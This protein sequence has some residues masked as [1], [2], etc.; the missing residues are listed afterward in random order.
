MSNDFFGYVKRMKYIKRWS[1]MHST[2][3]ENDMEHSM[4]VTVIAHAIALI[5]NK[6]FNKAYDINKVLTY[7]IYHECSEVITGDLPTP[8]KYFNRDIK[9]AYKDLE[10]EACKKLLS[11]LDEELV[12]EYEKALIP[13]K[14][15][16]EWAIVKCADR[17]AAYIKCIDE[18]NMGNK[19]FKKAHQSIG[20]DV[21]A[22]DIE[23]VKYFLDK[24]LPAFTK[25]L[26]ELD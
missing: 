3:E 8:I 12:P 17:V 10:L 7:A 26:D 9:T 4:E 23:E 24:M 1:L 18:V 13:D 14:D 16:P 22:I 21:K 6:K 20:K 5:G 25:T 15:S 19:E 2:F 11:S